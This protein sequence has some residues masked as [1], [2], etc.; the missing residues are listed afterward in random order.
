MHA[1][2]RMKRELGFAAGAAVLL[3]ALT[4]AGLPPFSTVMAVGDD[5]KNA[6]TV[7]TNEPPLPHAEEL[8][9]ERMA[10][11]VKMPADKARQNLAER[12]VKAEPGQTVQQIA[13]ANSLTPQQVFQKMQS[14]DA[15]PQVSL[16]GGGWGRKTV[17]GICRQYLIP[18]DTG[19][20]RLSEAGF[21]ATATTSL[22]DLALKAGKTP[23]DIA[24]II[25][26][27]DAEIA[28]PTSHQTAAAR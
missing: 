12:G 24:K 16:G 23:V 19:L 8:T 20:S 25:T 15:K 22:K 14:V 7:P 21:E 17:D 9:V 2:V 1:G 4:V 28:S 11:A 6:W 18:V 27:P 10:E 3:A 13:D 5:I 26:G